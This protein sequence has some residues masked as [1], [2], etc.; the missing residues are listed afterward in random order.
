M[1]I[2]LVVTIAAVV[3]AG[4]SGS[5]KSS[6]S[7]GSSESGESPC[8]AKG[9]FFK[10]VQKRS[11]RSVDSHNPGY[12][13]TKRSKNS[14][15][16]KCDD[17][18]K[19]ELYDYNNVIIKTYNGCRCANSQPPQPDLSYCTNHASSAI[20]KIAA[21]KPSCAKGVK[22][23]TCCSTTPPSAPTTAPSPVVT[24]P[25]T[26]PTTTPPPIVTTISTTVETTAAIPAEQSTL[27][28]DF[29]GNEHTDY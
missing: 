21:T 29:Y 7:N 8:K 9:N 12:S 22:I 4:S 20:C 28:G 11:S 18:S 15:V 27:L 10:N 1:I 23:Y 3:S 25:P 14:N 13:K 5:S 19:A 24:I 2:C 16:C 17:V 6:G 26:T